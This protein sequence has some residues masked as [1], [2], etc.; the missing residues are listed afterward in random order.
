MPEDMSLAI[1]TVKGWVLLSGCGHSGI[2]NTIDYIKEKTGAT[3]IL[4]AIGGF[5]LFNADDSTIEWTA[6]E[7]KKNG[8]AYFIGAH[9][10]GINAVYDIRRLT[11]LS[12]STA[13]VGAVGATF[14]IDKGIL[15]GDIAK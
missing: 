8:L 2:I 9:C 10:T 12:R 13:V 4:A 5:H 15:T 1:K 6:D 3:K 14:D 7:L 11:G